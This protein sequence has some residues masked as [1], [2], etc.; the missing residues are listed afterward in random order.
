MP[1]FTAISRERFA[2]KKWQ[3]PNGYSFASTSALVP[4]VGAELAAA[5]LAIPLALLQEGGRFA[6]V[7]ILSLTPGRNMLVAPDGRWV[8]SYVPANFRGYPFSLLAQEGTDQLAL[9]V[10]ANSGLVGEARSAGEDF[11]DHD[12]NLSPGLQKMLDF[13]GGLERSRKDTD[14]AVSALAEA[15]V[16]Q[17]WP[18]TLRTGQVER[19]IAGL[20]RIDEPALN[21]LTDNAF[22][23]LRKTSALPIAYAQ[24]VSMGRL[25]MFEELARLHARLA[26]P[27]PATLPENLD[28][29]FELPT[30][31][32]IQF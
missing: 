30:G 10:D 27:P 22:L 31:E 16:I 29:V 25:A 19:P 17:S 2:G 26:P 21:T 23:K 13:L 11:F 8:G 6:L 4:I 32:T 7:G 20:H 3:R 5:S 15:R 9:C 28:S 14:V 12:G 18:I 24:L 1:Q